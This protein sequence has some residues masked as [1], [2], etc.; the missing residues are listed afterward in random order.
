MEDG[1]LSQ[2]MVEFFENNQ[3]LMNQ[4]VIK[5][6]LASSANFTLF[7]KAIE[8]PTTVNKSAL[9]QAFK[10]FYKDLKMRKYITSLIRF[11]AIDYDKK[12]KKVQGSNELLLDDEDFL[13]TLASEPLGDIFW[14]NSLEELV[15]DEIIT[16]IIKENLSCKQKQVL[17]LYY[18]EGFSNKEIAAMF[19]E[20]QQR[21]S[22]CRVDALKKIRKN[23]KMRCCYNA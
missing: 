12:R 6:F 4:P 14:D 15:E 18:I 2:N 10:A 1:K 3:E 9:D 5:R 8:N 19:G 11:F 7:V 13:D 17:H 20:S 21:V 22:K 23:F 16:K